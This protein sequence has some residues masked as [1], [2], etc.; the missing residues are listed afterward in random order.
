MGTVRWWALL[1]IVVALPGCTALE[2]DV[3]RLF[4][5]TPYATEVGS[6]HWVA[7]DP[8]PGYSAWTSWWEVAGEVVPGTIE[9]TVRPG[10]NRAVLAHEGGHVVCL[11]RGRPDPSEACAAAIARTTVK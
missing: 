2:R 4:A 5:R 10:W 6:A 8:G 11:S 9:V 3:G 7:G 1:G